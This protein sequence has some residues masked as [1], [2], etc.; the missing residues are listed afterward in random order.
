MSQL[1]NT[2]VLLDLILMIKSHLDDLTEFAFQQFVK[3]LIKLKILTQ[4]N[5]Q[6]TPPP[7][8]QAA[9][10]ETHPGVPQRAKSN[11]LAISFPAIKTAETIY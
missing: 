9:E 7:Q 11:Q 5:R 6:A 1:P 10:P 2:N 8:S 4:Q 3:K